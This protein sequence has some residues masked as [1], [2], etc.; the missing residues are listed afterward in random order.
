MTQFEISTLELGGFIFQDGPALKDLASLPT[1][2]VTVEK[3]LGT[4]FR[5]S[6]EEPTNAPFHLPDFSCKFD[7]GHSGSLLMSFSN[8]ILSSSHGNKCP[9]LRDGKRIWF[10]PRPSTEHL[11]KMEDHRSIS[12][13]IM[14]YVKVPT[15]GYGVV[16]TICTPELVDR[17]EMYEVSILNY[18]ACSCHDFKFMKAQTNRK[19][20]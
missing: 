2:E 14:K 16:L 8:Q 18:H 4:G 15:L 3:D 1:T 12:C 13:T 6:L 20:K 11:K 5:V 7:V 17:K 19:R 9:T 10:V